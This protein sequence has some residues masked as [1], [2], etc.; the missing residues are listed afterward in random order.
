M[1]I[2]SFCGVQL[3]EAPVLK[4][5][6]FTESI[7]QMSETRQWFTRRAGN[8]QR[9]EPRKPFYQRPDQPA[10]QSRIA[11][12]AGHIRHRFIRLFVP[13]VFMPRRTVSSGLVETWAIQAEKRIGEGLSK[14]DAYKEISQEYSFSV[15]TV[16]R[17]LT[18]GQK[19]RHKRCAAIYRS[20]HKAEI[21]ERAS[22]YRAQHKSEVAECNRRRHQRPEVKKAFNDYMRKYLKTRY[23][24][25]EYIDS[26]LSTSPTTLTLDGLS[27]GLTEKTGIR[28]KRN[29]I[30]RCL[31]KY[32]QD[33][34]FS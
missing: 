18:P 1:A 7:I 14:W 17:W 10:H 23:H 22:L 2:K 13:I 5:V 34:F 8:Y 25:R 24:L 32:G 21:A 12:S 3:I 31:E 6:S 30:A 15:G 33:S 26:L 29:T 28:F 16:Y 4:A 19:E 11:H 20:Q 9:K 27:E